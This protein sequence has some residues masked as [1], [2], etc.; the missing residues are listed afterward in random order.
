MRSIVN[1]AGAC[2]RISATFLASAFPPLRPIP[3]MA[4][5]IASFRHPTRSS[6]SEVRPSSRRF[7]FV[8]FWLFSFCHAVIW[9]AGAAYAESPLRERID[10]GF[11]EIHPGPEV[12][13]CSDGEFLRR[14]YLD[15]IGRIPTGSEAREFLSDASA[16]K[17]ERVV[18]KLLAHP[19]HV[20]HMAAVLD[21]MLM[22]RRASKYVK[23]TEWESYLLTS[24]QE[25]KPYNVLARE[26]LS[27]DGA[28]EGKRGAAKFY[29]ER[30][31][32]PNLVT[33][34]VGR[35][36]FGM[37]LQC[38]QCHDHPS[39]DDYYQA[40]YYGLFGF[41]NRSYL[42]QPDKK[43]PAVLAEKADGDAKFKSVFTDEEGATLPRL[44]GAGEIT[45]PRFL[46]GDSYKVAP[47]PKKKD[48]RPIPKH[49][50]RQQ[51]ARLATD[52]SNAAFN[53]NIA[54][55]TWAVMFGRGLVHPVDQHHS[56][57]PPV[58]PALLDL[59]AEELAR[60]DFNLQAM[61]REIALSR[62]YQRGC[63]LPADVG[64]HASAAAKQIDSWSQRLADAQSQVEQLRQRRQSQH[65]ELQQRR[66]EL[67]PLIE[68]VEKVSAAQIEVKKVADQARQKWDEARTKSEKY[69]EVTQTLKDAIENA[70]QA[71]DVLGPDVKP[72]VESLSEQMKV[73]DAKFPEQEKLV[74]SLFEKHESANKKLQ[75]AKAATDAKVAELEAVRA[76]I[77]PLAKSFVRINDDLRV[78]QTRQRHA[79]RQV[80]D[81]QLVIDL[82][83]STEEL[84]HHSTD[85]AGRVA[86]LAEHRRD[87]K[88]VDGSLKELTAQL[89]DTEKEQTRLASETK[90]AKHAMTSAGQAAKL[91]T[92]SITSAGEAAALLAND[93]KIAEALDRLS[94]ASRHIDE[95][96]DDQK[97]KLAQASVTDKK[98]SL[99]IGTT[100]R[101]IKEL[102]KRREDLSRTIQQA[103]LQVTRDRERKQLLHESVAAKRKSVATAWSHRFAIAGIRPLTPEQLVGSMLHATGHL[104]RLRSSAKAVVEKKTPLKPEDVRDAKKLA[105]HE[106][107]IES[108]LKT[109]IDAIQGRFV[110]L[111]AAAGG[112]PQDD[113]FATVDQAL[114][115]RNGGDL[116][117]W[118]TPTGG[119]L[120]DRLR[121][122]DD[123]AALAEELYLSLL[124]R[125]PTN[126]EVDDVK[127]YLALPESDKRE[128]VQQLAWALI[129]SVEFRFQ[130]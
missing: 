98:L 14:V 91:L 57:N 128:A 2:S 124:T 15:L 120:T 70:R 130:H 50:R 85:Q 82:Q 75:E 115:F 114:F 37:D 93:K 31:V 3:F 74:K 110:K 23:K 92:D 65:N 48:V 52:G 1:R 13:L 83:K 116:R 43:K 53:R 71:I 122:I 35:M 119:N 89:R 69:R 108:Q 32:E 99:S 67:P 96:I 16:Q 87:M 90:N 28:D 36:F 66:G 129:T 126:D 12:T 9:F 46:P 106:A 97:E 38:A 79:E 18:D 101:E 78:A 103:E 62:T 45:E 88:A 29:L 51:L 55:R 22:E 20:R 121:Q 30:E 39:I 77:A 58:Q 63:E 59:L 42:F 84:K 49:S 127:D 11:R 25:G 68:S 117:S 102:K 123:P 105:Q 10:Q 109:S 41:V 24:L 47:D 95:L 80:F 26:I 17:R 8:L 118:L 113:F 44:P 64:I 100:Q 19:D 72:A 73:F 61:M 21:V 76:E 56:D 60:T 104:E 5:P 6:R 27:A 33:R 40:D 54:N 86:Q 107:A 111:F 94:G 125:M 34:E 112:Q 4:S 7:G 81:L